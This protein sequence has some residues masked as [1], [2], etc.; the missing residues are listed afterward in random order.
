MVKKILWYI[1]N[2]PQQGTNKDTGIGFYLKTRGGI[3]LLLIM[4]IIDLVIS[5][6]SI[7]IEEVYSMGLSAGQQ[8]H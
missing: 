2:N 6:Y 1:Q 3:E 5:Q 4:E 8:R 7:D